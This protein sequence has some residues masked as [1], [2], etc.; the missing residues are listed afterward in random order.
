MAVSTHDL[1]DGALLAA[2]PLFQGRVQSALIA[3]CIAIANETFAQGGGLHAF[4]L[5]LVHAI[6]ASV[7]AI[8]DAV[9]RFSISAATS[10][11]VLSD[12]T[13]GGTVPLTA[14][15]VAAQQALVTD[16]T[17]NAAVSSQFN[18]FAQ[19]IPI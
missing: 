18:T 19:Q 17:I 14:A 8:N 12:A 6:V 13:A 15:N 16:A 1:N 10:A 5:H 3:A 2:Q 11:A 7:A 9:L 4:R